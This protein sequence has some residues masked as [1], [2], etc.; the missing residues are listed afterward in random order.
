[1]DRFINQEGYFECD[2]VLDWEPVEM[3]ECGGDVVPRLS[4]AEY[5]GG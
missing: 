4:V 2:L 5:S 3:K 1:M